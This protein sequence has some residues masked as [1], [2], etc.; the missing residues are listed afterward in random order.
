[1][2]LGPLAIIIVWTAYSMVYYKTDRTGHTT[3]SGVAASTKKNYWIFSTGLFVSGVLMFLFV[4]LWYLD[5]LDLPL[6]FLY[7]TGLATLL[8]QPLIAF[9]PYSKG[10]KTII[11]N[12]AA[13][14]ESAILPILAVFI[15]QSRQL[16][17]LIR[18]VCWLILLI[19]LYSF[20][21][22]RRQFLKPRFIHV[23]AVYTASFHLIILLTT[24]SIIIRV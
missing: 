6:T 9:V 4:R 21:E 1:M 24:F 7:L 10:V 23:Q 13:Y 5:A 3:L 8:F 12:I 22:F 15:A 2:Q 14:A 16:P 19:M 17:F 18:T 20:I 11:H